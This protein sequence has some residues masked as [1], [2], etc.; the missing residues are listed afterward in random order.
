MLALK[1]LAVNI[2]PDVRGIPFPLQRCLSRIY[3]PCPGALKSIDKVKMVLSSWETD[4]E[5]TLALIFLPKSK[6]EVVFLRFRSQ[7][8]CVHLVEYLKVQNFVGF[9]L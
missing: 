7:F 5:Q 1:L 6:Y 8:H 2:N 4:F 3:H 9:L